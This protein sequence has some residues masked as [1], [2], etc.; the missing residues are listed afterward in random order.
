MIPTIDG[1]G[2]DGGNAHCSE[3]SDDGSKDQEYIV[4]ES[5]VPKALLNILSI[6]DLAE[7]S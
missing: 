5:Y 3:K 6:M 2:P 7:Q 1:L 4:P